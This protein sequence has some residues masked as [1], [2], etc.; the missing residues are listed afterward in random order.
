[1]TMGTW[2]H[3]PHKAK[4]CNDV[5]LLNTDNTHNNNIWAIAQ[6]LLLWNLL[7]H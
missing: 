7:R 2:T 1:M 6:T 4:Y 3:M 5:T